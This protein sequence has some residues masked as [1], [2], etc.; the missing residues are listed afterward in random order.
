[1]SVL[2]CE[3]PAALD[4]RGRPVSLGAVLE[5]ASI[6]ETIVNEM[7]R[8]ISDAGLVGIVILM[9]LDTAWLGKSSIVPPRWMISSFVSVAISPARAHFTS[10]G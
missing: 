4:G 9:T 7:S 1:M 8:V 3:P 2:S 6:S 5:L 10:R